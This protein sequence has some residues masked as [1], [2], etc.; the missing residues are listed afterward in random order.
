MLVQS[1]NTEQLI[2]ESARKHFAAR[3]FSGVSLQDIAADAGTTKSMVN[4]YFR[5]KEKLFSVI[6][7]REFQLLFSSIASF[8]LEDL[9]LKEKI[10][11][12]VSLDVDRLLKMPELPVFIMSEMHRNPEIVL[13]HLEHIPIDQLLLQL[14][15]QIRR[16]TKQGIIR[17][18]PPRELMINIQSLTIFPFLSKPMMTG[19]LGYTEKTFTALMMKRKK[20][21]VDTIWK[22]IAV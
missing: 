20:D 13:K 2:I 8:L 14:D 12:I 15:K 4:Y 9:P 6:F 1:L 16:E 3:G 10:T 11:N 7:L 22:S 17:Y 19:R 21:I 18:I 5:S